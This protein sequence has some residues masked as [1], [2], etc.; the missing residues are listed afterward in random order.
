MEGLLSCPSPT[1]ISPLDG[2]E[3]DAHCHQLSSWG[4]LSG[5]LISIKNTHQVCLLH[6]VKFLWTCSPAPIPT[7]FIVFSLRWSWLAKEIYGL[8]GHNAPG[9]FLWLSPCLQSNSWCFHGFWLCSLLS[10]FPKILIRCKTIM[11]PSLIFSLCI[12]KKTWD[13]LHMSTHNHFLC[14]FCCL[15]VHTKP[16]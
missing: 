15:P 10:P 14:L 5:K 11:S 6:T 13:L 16:F 4:I 3:K 7:L 8:T 9:Q 12:S 2:V 1:A